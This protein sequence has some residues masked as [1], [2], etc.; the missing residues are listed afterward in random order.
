[1][2]CTRWGRGR[3]DVHTERA[4]DGKEYENWRWNV[5]TK[6]INSPFFSIYTK[7]RNSPSLEAR[8]KENGR[9]FGM[10]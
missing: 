1:V 10:R 6:K 3:E 5:N 2:R 9:E 7:S 4:S 8:V